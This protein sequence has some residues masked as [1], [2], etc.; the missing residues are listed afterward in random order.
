MSTVAP[1][2][3]PS[4]RFLTWPSTRDGRRAGW[5]SL[6][7]LGLIALEGLLGWAGMYDWSQGVRI[8]LGFVTSVPIMLGSILAAVYTVLALGKGDRSIVLLWPLLLGAFAAMFV[9]GECAF[10]H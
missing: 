4:H 7:V 3:T 10:P 8:A 6:A 1:S 9:V 2:G 5:L